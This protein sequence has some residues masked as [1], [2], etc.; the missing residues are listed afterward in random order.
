MRFLLLALPLLFIA[1]P[2]SAQ[3]VVPLT[4]PDGRVGCTQGKTGIGRPADWRAVADPDGPDGWALVESEPDATDQ[5]FPLCISEPASGRDF[6]ATLRFKPISGSRDQVA[7]F[8]FRAQSANDYYVVRANA[9]DN[10]VRL[11]RMDKG[12]RSQLA[13]KEAPVTLGQ[14]HSLRVIAAGDRFEVALDGKKLFDV[15]DRTLMQPGP[16]GV[17]SQGDSVTHYGS[18]LIGP[19]PAR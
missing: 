16:V 5:R 17:W 3:L 14:W 10:S 13:M 6:D 11:Y 15:T 2:A 7:G 8:M 9:R 19:P 4:T 1:L 18:L 12:K